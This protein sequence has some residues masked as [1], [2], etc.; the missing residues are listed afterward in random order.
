M[1]YLRFA[2]L[3]SALFALSGC[4]KYDVD[5]PDTP[6]NRAGFSK[7]I[8]FDPGEEVSEVY[9]Y[10][11]ELGGDVRYQLSFKCNRDIAEKIR[12]TLSLSPAPQD[13]FVLAPRDDLKWWDENSTRDR[14][15]WIKVDDKKYYREFWFSEEDGRG[16][17]HEYSS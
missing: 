11:D 2:L 15:H 7:H 14:E 1:K 6:S 17:Y 12:T 4:T 16:F 3:L 5:T 10:A 8:G 13:H 9:Y